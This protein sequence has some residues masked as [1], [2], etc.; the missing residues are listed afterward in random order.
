L[1]PVPDARSAGGTGEA[2]ARAQA[3]PSRYFAATAAIT[4]ELRAEGVKKIVDVA[5]RYKITTAGVFSS[6]ESIDGIFN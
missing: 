5:D 4:P 6:G 3:A 1:L 2:S